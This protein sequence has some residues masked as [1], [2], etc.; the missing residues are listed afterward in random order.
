MIDGVI[1]KNLKKIPDDRG[2]IL[3]IMK[4]SDTEF[5]NLER[6]IVQQF[7]LNR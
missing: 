6:F 2:N 1:V 4:S 3:H 7:I 5:K